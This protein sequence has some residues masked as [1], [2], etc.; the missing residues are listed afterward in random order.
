MMRRL[1]SSV[2]AFSLLIVASSSVFAQTNSPANPAPPTNAPAAAKQVPAATSSA[3]PTTIDGFRDAAAQFAL[4]KRFLAV[5][6]AKLA[7]Q[8]LQTLTKAPHLAGTPE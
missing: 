6:S 2:V 4:E 3:A 7:E 8:H 1:L 5:P